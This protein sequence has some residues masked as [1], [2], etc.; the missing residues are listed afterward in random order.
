M[1]AHTISYNL[2]LLFIWSYSAYISNSKWL[3]WFKFL[4]TMKHYKTLWNL[5]A[6]IVHIIYIANTHSHIPYTLHSFTYCN[7]GKV[8]CWS[9]NILYI[10]PNYQKILCPNVFNYVKYVWDN[11]I[12]EINE[13][14]SLL[15]EN[16]SIENTS[17][18]STRSFTWTL[19]QVFCS[20]RMLCLSI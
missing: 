17:L 6:Y 9:I 4:E 5:C 2:N 1:W 16:F 18:S 12:L 3:D 13:I 14:K 11:M 15:P 7:L 8:R 20:S 10:R 19:P